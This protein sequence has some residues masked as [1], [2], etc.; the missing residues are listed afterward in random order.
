MQLGRFSEDIFLRHKTQ[1]VYGLDPNYLYSKNPELYKL[2][3]EIT[4]GNNNDPA[5]IIREKFGAR[6]I[7][8]D[9][10]EN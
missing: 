8:S 6:F 7:F 9:I 3:D 4:K 2:I 1:L 5:P 10:K